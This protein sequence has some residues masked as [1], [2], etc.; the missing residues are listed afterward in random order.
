MTPETTKP[1][2][3]V[4]PNSTKRVTGWLVRCSVC[5]TVNLL[6][7]S[8]ITANTVAQAHS[9]D[10]HDRRAIIATQIR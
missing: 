9:R 5:R 2:I 10:V 1:R 7:R 8:K 3:T 6:C 4:K